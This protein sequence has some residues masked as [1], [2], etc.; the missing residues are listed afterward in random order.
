MSELIFANHLPTIAQGLGLDVQTSC[1]A[2]RGFR[3]HLSDCEISIIWGLPAGSESVGV[4]SDGRNSVEI[5]I[6]IPGVDTDPTGWIS[7][8]DVYSFLRSV[9]QGDNV[10]VAA[11]YYISNQSI[12][13]A[14][15][16]YKSEIK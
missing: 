15:P 6:Q 1:Y 12:H 4:H 16:E 11:G 9:S 14:M 5:W 3:V 2:G 10:R 8:Y 7:V 13:G